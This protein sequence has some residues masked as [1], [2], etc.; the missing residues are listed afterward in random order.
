[1]H[2][3]KMLILGANGQLGREFQSSLSERKIEFI[4]P[5]ESDCDI[6]QLDHLKRYIEQT[7]PATIINCAAYN[8]VDDAEKDNSLA[9]LINHKAV[10]NLAR[11]CEENGASLVHYSSDY[12]FDG[13]KGDLYTENDSPNPLNEYGKSKLAGEDAVLSNLTSGLVLRLSWVYGPGTQNFLHKL[14][15]WAS[16]NPI[17][18]I[19][20]DEASVPTST[21][22]IVTATLALL[23]NQRT[24]LF[25]VTNSGYCSRYEWARFALDQLGLSNT[26]IPVAMSNFQSPA[27]RPLFSA[28]S[29][30]NVSK[31]IAQQIPDWKEST[32]R[33]LK[34]D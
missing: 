25:H 20:S 11:I 6:T 29:N 7:E 27:E 13:K 3:Q 33:F 1:M 5:N 9:F 12:V 34:S 32:E 26:I 10:E 31:I 24:G 30:E 23:E 22:D 19:S 16:N 18:K 28:M 14:K 21:Q 4:A 2:N 17:L 15:N 8:A